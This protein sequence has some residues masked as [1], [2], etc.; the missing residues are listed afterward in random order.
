MKKSCEKGSLCK[1]SRCKR[2]IYETREGGLGVKHMFT[3]GIVLEEITRLNDM[4]TKSQIS[5]DS[6]IRK[7]VDENF[8]DLI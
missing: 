6:E 2:E 4:I 7:V 3:C 1:N 8:W 5:I